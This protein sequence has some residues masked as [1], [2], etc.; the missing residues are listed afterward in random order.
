MFIA[1]VAK[2]LLKMYIRARG[3]GLAAAVGAQGKK[4]NRHI[5]KVKSRMR[6]EFLEM[7]IC[8]DA[9]VSFSFSGVIL[10]I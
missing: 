1:L 10:C 9:E 3:P 2:K 6:L 7:L 4:L 5:S 8:S